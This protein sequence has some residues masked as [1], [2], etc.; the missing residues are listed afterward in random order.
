MAETLMHNLTVYF[1]FPRKARSVNLS[2]QMIR[3]RLR[4]PG[5]HGRTVG[6]RS[7]LQSKVRDL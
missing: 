1:T 6:R 4:C 7:R 2:A 5:E 3:P